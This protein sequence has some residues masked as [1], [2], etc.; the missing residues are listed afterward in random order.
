MGEAKAPLVLI[1]M[2]SESDLPK[3]QPAAEE[4]DR[5]GLPYEMHVASAHRTP[6]RVA[7]LA[8]EARSRGI[9]VIIAAAGGAA[10]LAGT[11]AAHTTLPVIGLPI[12]S[13]SLGGLDA[14]LST[15]QM[16]R[17]VPVA[18]V[19]INGAENAALLAAQ[20]LAIQD[21]ALAQRLAKMRE[22]MAQRVEQADQN[23]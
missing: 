9:K 13:G 5:L 14:L 8:R 10:H 20:I 7:T 3:V 19:A 21:L 18:A 22:E 12:A 15:V 2:G 16:P 6:D 4:L 17:G 23:L 1:A 11:F